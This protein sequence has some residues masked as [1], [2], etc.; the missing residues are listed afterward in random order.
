MVGGIE[1][2]PMEPTRKLGLHIGADAGSFERYHRTGHPRTLGVFFGRKPTGGAF[3]NVE[4]ESLTVGG[5]VQQPM[6]PLPPTV[7]GTLDPRNLTP[8][9]LLSAVLPVRLTAGTRSA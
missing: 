7:V 1:M 8:E 4:V 3:A 2:E 6:A 5:V 9:M